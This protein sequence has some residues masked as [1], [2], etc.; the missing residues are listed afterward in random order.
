MLFFYLM[1]GLGV[2]TSVCL[3]VVGFDVD[4]DFDLSWLTSS[5]EWV[6]PSTMLSALSRLATTILN[7]QWTGYV[8]M[9]AR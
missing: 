9:H 1:G 3:S 4:V 6:S 2:D 7:A 8:R 5:L